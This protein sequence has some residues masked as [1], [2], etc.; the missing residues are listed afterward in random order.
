M[1][2]IAERD[3]FDLLERSSKR[4]LLEYV[5]NSTCRKYSK[6]QVKTKCEKSL[7]DEFCFF[8]WVR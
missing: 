5:K 2:Q 3:H 1:D 4:D 6:A 8:W 7:G